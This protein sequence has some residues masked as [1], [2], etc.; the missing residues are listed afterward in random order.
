MLA[1]KVQEAV[2]GV[3][4][5]NTFTCI[6]DV[7]DYH[8]PLFRLMRRLI[9]NNYWPSIK[10]I[11]QVRVPILLIV[12]TGDE[13]IPTN[14]SWKL[15]EAATQAPFKELHLVPGGMHN[16]TW[17]LSGKDYLHAVRMF[18]IKTRTFAIKQAEVSRKRKTLVLL[19]DR[20]KVY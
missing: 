13:I 17:Q 6:G 20:L 7:A 1:E 19:K 2:Q 16:D 11:P 10:R 18:L 8:F 3:I 12:G 5:E 14:H 9:I 15:Y 4:M